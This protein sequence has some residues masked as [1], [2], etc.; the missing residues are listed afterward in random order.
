[1][2]KVFRV[3]ES[4]TVGR[5]LC[6]WRFAA[7]HTTMLC[8]AGIIDFSGKF[9]ESRRR[10]H[11]NIITRIVRGVCDERSICALLTWNGIRFPYV[12]DMV[13]VSGI[14]LGFGQK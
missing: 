6:S 4:L 7:H 9:V 11:N 13:R 12:F 5:V 1:M 14:R 8:A 2:C 3:F 10:S